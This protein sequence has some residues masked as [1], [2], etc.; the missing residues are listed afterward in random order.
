MLLLLLLLETLAGRTTETIAVSLDPDFCLVW[1]LC[2]L[3]D[4]GREPSNEHIKQLRNPACDL[5]TFLLVTISKCLD[6]FSRSV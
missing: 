4:I 2:M 5:I 6:Y 3:W 1:T